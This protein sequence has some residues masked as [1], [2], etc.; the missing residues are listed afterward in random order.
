MLSSLCATEVTIGR[1]KDPQRGTKDRQKQVKSTRRP[2]VSKAWG[3]S[4]GRNCKVGPFG[5]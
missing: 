4:C 3:S 1:L 5:G 2:V